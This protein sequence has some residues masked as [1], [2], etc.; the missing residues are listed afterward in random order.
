MGFIIVMLV[1]IFGVLLNINSKIP[2]RD[3]TKEAMERDS[4][5]KEQE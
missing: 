5:R 1:L 3:H 2:P 4:A